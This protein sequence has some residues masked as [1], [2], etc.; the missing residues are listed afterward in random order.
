[1]ND[2]QHSTSQDTTWDS[3]EDTGPSVFED[4]LFQRRFALSAFGDTATV[5]QEEPDATESALPPSGMEP[6]ALIN[7]R[8]QRVGDLLADSKTEPS[9]SDETRSAASKEDNDSTI[10]AVSIPT[11]V[12]RESSQ[13]STPDSRTSEGRTTSQGDE[14]SEVKTGPEAY[15]S[16][17]TI[18]TALPDDTVQDRLCREEPESEPVAT[19]QII[20]PAALAKAASLLAIAADEYMKEQADIAHRKEPRPIALVQAKTFVE[21]VQAAFTAPAPGD[22]QSPPQAQPR[23]QQQEVTRHDPNLPLLPDTLKLSNVESEWFDT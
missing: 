22:S 17:T 6:A 5:R 16:K 21:A 10:S 15:E 20:D 7:H 11:G 4:A 8:V 1:M 23:A 19:K 18:P 2:D 13:G 9:H 12:T 3:F 14:S